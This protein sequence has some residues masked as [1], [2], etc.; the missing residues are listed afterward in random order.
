MRKIYV[1]WICVN[2]YKKNMMIINNIK[3]KM[4]FLVNIWIKIREYGL[5]F[6][7]RYIKYFL[8]IRY[9]N[10]LENIDE[11]E[12]NFKS[13]NENYCIKCGNININCYFLN[14]I[15]DLDVK[16]EK[17]YVKSLYIIIPKNILKNQKIKFVFTKS[18]IKIGKIGKKRKKENK[19]EKEKQLRMSLL[20][21]ESDDFRNSGKLVLE[22]ID[23][24]EYLKNILDNLATN[25]SLIFKKIYIYEKSYNILLKLSLKTRIPNIDFS[26]ILNN[27][28][29]EMNGYNFLKIKVGKVS[30]ENQKYQIYVKTWT[31]RFEKN[32]LMKLIK[33]YKDHKFLLNNNDKSEISFNFNQIEIFYEYDYDIVVRINNFKNNVIKDIIC[34]ITNMNYSIPVFSINEIIYNLNKMKKFLK[35]FKINFYLYSKLLPKLY[36]F[37]NELQ[38][39]YFL[40]FHVF[41]IFPNE[42]KR[43]FH[44]SN[45]RELFRND[46]HVKSGEFDKLDD[47]DIFNLD[48]LGD[49]KDEIDDKFIN[50]YQSDDIFL[51]GMDE[52][53]KEVDDNE[54]NNKKFLWEIKKINIII[55]DI[56]LDDEESCKNFLK[57][58][59][60]KGIENIL[61]KIKD[62]SLLYL[63][64]KNKVEKYLFL[65][66]R[67]EIHDNIEK[68]LWKKFFYS[69]NIHNEMIEIRIIDKSCFKNGGLEIN[70][71]L[72][73]LH[74]NIDEDCLYF[75]I[76][77]IK[78]NRIIILDDTNVIYK[79]KK[80]IKKLYF[81]VLDIQLSY[82]PKRIIWGDLFLG[83]IQQLF[84][85]G[86]IHDLDILFSDLYLELNVTTI[87]T[88]K[89]ILKRWGDEFRANEA[90]KWLINIEPFGY[91]TTLINNYIVFKKS[92]N[93]LDGAKNVASNISNDIFNISSK[94]LISTQTIL[95]NCTSEK[96]KKSKYYNPPKNLKEGIDH[97]YDSIRKRYKNCKNKDMSNKSLLLQP[98]IGV[99]EVSSKT[100]IGV[101]NNLF[102]KRLKTIQNRYGCDDESLL[103]SDLY[104]DTLSIFNNK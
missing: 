88:I 72:S 61:I 24:I 12:F 26:M 10:Y 46:F 59:Q 35:M 76:K 103:E 70:V 14:G 55:F 1:Y 98:L 20:N 97:A 82:K 69:G 6:L 40:N 33:I 19:D 42:S 71:K 79:K 17:F 57:I 64:K 16:L 93:I 39:I 47:E 62:I 78:S 63:K 92:N 94:T 85:I 54:R 4:D 15:N 3:K 95:E 56:D 83:N 18:F 29:I 9:T 28:N 68:S 22:K 89:I 49:Y 34:E 86:E 43:F 65:I 90:L 52:M 50:L 5:I 73:K 30:L 66:N 77:N 75:L 25:H 91:L 51:G 21:N 80:L 99:A 48:K 58:N 84:Q 45:E 11:I 32:I 96:D 2:I 13:N 74:F 27:L 87:E 81:G 101:H 31:T 23:S 44:Y 37:M 8:K 36:S 67:F 41:E 102:P 53:N 100:I 60:N 104:D 38:E 7:N